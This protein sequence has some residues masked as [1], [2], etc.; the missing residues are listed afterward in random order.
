MKSDGTP[1]WRDLRRYWSNNFPNTSPGEKQ[2][3]ERFIKVNSC[4]SSETDYQPEVK[5]RGILL[6]TWERGNSS[7]RAMY[8]FN[9][10]STESAQHVTDSTRCWDI[11]NNTHLF[12]IWITMATWAILICRACCHGEPCTDSYPGMLSPVFVICST[13]TRTLLPLPSPLFLSLSLPYHEPWSK[14]NV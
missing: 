3:E 8:N 7:W 13:T 12:F 1:L 5:L 2:R 9:L 6:A 4:W 10:S 14:V 11:P